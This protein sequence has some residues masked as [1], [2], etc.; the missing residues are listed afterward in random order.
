[1]AEFAPAELLSLFQR[2]QAS[3]TDRVD[4]VGPGQWDDGALPGWTVADLVAHLVSESLWAPPLLAGEPFD[5]IDGRFPDET[6]DL[7]GDDPLT[8]WESAAD[9]AL[10]A[11][12]QDR[13]LLHTVHL[14]RGPTSA[15]EYLEELTADLTVHSWD[16]AS[17]TD[18]DT[19]L[20]PALVTAALVVADRLPADGVRG[21][22]DPP[23]DV[24][25]TA[26]PQVRL[27]GRYGRRS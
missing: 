2:A 23:L 14:Q 20:D 10:A 6:S 9:G 4:A 15:A 16:L 12:A 18:G 21:L 25:R 17:A 7:L 27:L 26:P 22:F 11:F 5:L 13:A 1:M 24:P 3:F 8:G 19:E